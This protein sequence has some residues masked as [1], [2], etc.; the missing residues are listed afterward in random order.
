MK[1]YSLVIQNT[2]DKKYFVSGFTDQEDSKIYYHIK[3]F[4]FPEGY[5]DGEYR[6][7]VMPE[8][9]KEITA[10]NDNIYFDGVRVEPLAT[11]LICLGEYKNPN[12]QYNKKE[13]F[14]QYE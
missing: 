12:T 9:D 5:A 10:D 11:G 4:V 14:I 3:R 6:Y 8:T 1:N 13:T 7:Y 2:T